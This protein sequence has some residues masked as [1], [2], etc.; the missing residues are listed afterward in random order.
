MEFQKRKAQTLAAMASPA[1]D[2]SPKGNLDAPIIPLLDAINNDPSYFTTSSCSGRIS[3][4]L[5]LPPSAASTKKKARGGTWIFISHDP[6]DPDF[7]VDLLFGARDRTDD[8]G[9]EMVFRFEPLIVAVECRD[10]DAAQA[11]V[12]TAIA[13][14]FR[15][16]GIT[17]AGKR[18]MVAIRC[19]IRLEVPLGQ[20]GALLVSPEY[21]RY[22]V[23]IANE[24][25]EANR[26]R[27]DGFLNVLQCKGLRQ[28]VTEKIGYQSC[29]VP[30]ESLLNLESKQNDVQSKILL[31]E[32][33]A[34]KVHEQ[35]NIGSLDEDA[36]GLESNWFFREDNGNDASSKTPLKAS[37][38][39]H[40][41]EVE[42]GNSCRSH[43]LRETVNGLSEKGSLL[44][45][46][47]T[48]FDE[49]PE[50]L[51]LWGQSACV[52]NDNEHKQ[53]F[54]FG[55]F[56]GLGRHARRN[57][58]LMLDPKSGTLKEIN[59][60]DSPSPRMGHTSS[61]IGDQI[62]V[63]G[64]RDGPTQIF[65]EVWV[66]NNV[67]SRWNL[68]KC[69]GSMFHPRHRHA[70]A[71]VGSNIYVFGGLGYEVIYSCMNVLHTETLQW[72]E[73]SVQGECPC[74]RHSHSLVAY[75]SQLFLFG[76]Y[77]G[78]K[79]L[80]DLYSFDVRTLHWEKV[81]T[82][83]RSPCPRF[84]HS[85]FIYKNYLGI[86]GGCPV[87]Q[88]NQELALLNLDHQ[89]WVYV[90][91]VCLGRE[92]WVRCSTTVV[93]D[94]LVIVGGGASC[95]AF[96]TKFNP[97]MKVNL[98]QLETLHVTHCHKLVKQGSHST[99]QESLQNL[100]VNGCGNF[101]DAEHLVLKII[102]KNAK[103][104]KDILKKFGWLDTDRKVRPSVDGSYICIPV[105]QNFFAL[106]Q[107]KPHGS[108]NVDIMDD[109]HQ[110]EI[111]ET[112]SISVHEVSLPMALSFIS[113]SGS[114]LLKDS[115]VCDRKVSKSPQ[116]IMRDFVSSLLRKKGLPPQL[117]DELPTR[118]ERLG[119]IVVL[120]VTSFKD[121]AWN[122]MGEELWPIVANSIGAQRLARQGRILA[123]GTRDTTLEI[124]VGDNGWVTHQENG[125]FYSF[126]ATKCM[127]SSGNLS[128]K[129]RMAQLD[130]RDEII[131][132]LFAGIGYFVLPF[133][134]KAKAKL[135][136]ACEWNPHAINALRH[137]IDTNSVADRCVILEG[138]NRITAPKG[139]ADRVCLGLLPTS[140]GSWVTAVRSL[141]SLFNHLT[142]T[143][144]FD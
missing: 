77:D 1:P 15:E 110:P 101:S 36:C 84:S 5:S 28:L 18:V 33:D 17:N 136:Y 107:K 59:T 144:E 94:D 115:A 106:I 91:V 37:I 30:R 139:I 58:S 57:Y 26:R 19:S 9:G 133:L 132:D 103:L 24:K 73:V 16:S 88:E 81:K 95:Y 54:I 23:G 62:F 41:V 86:I 140:E 43:K 47:L 71:A 90:T 128:E 11:L 22:L 35:H 134:V 31:I 135:V 66:L 3:I 100:S 42:S 52:V 64:G 105:N 112:K 34:V 75:G 2:K 118:W 98:Q 124:L 78:E 93:D 120:P 53:I 6:A 87:R 143:T 38:C 82:N 45:V 114:S 21:V 63:I 25:M 13:S 74:A 123:T 116:S 10:I 72:T 48:I 70:A 142:E 20:S 56:G 12:S 97:P 89:S 27:T 79:A 39:L 4:L 127:F 69:N 99:F 80:G 130:C 138:D 122:S 109:G 29:M 126:D 131:V 137:N 67:E 113:S 14:G 83:G 119:D 8:A 46:Y 104:A 141:K 40:E 60:V 65:D 68:L 32:S 117:L 96:G 125:I 92:L 111:F 76:G 129:L 102:K 121:Q 55:G 49:P 7:L 50:K 51:Y 85:M 61:L 44:A 108:M